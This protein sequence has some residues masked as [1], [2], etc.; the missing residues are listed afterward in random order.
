MPQV[1]QLRLSLRDVSPLIWRRLLIRSDSTITDL[2][3]TIQYAMTW[4]DVYLH[5]FVIRGKQYGVAKIGTWGFMDEADEVHLNQFNWQINETF[6]YTYNY[7]DQ[8]HLVLRLEA[9]LPLVT[10]QFYPHCIGGKRAAPPEDCGG[11][12]QFME[13]KAHYSTGYIY[14]RLL[15]ILNDPDLAE[16]RWDYA[17]EVE[18][19]MYWGNVDEFDRRNVNQALQEHF[20]DEA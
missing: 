4:D 16:T 3:H 18:Y 10:D 12:W 1:Y 2:H 15:T 13:L 19:L 8:W 7:F 14:D 5:H 17:E 9:V 6:D 11:A 20:G